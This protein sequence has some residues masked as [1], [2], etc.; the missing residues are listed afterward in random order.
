MRK[1]FDPLHYLYDPPV[2]GPLQLVLVLVSSAIY[3]FYRPGRFMNRR[4]SVFEEF[5]SGNPSEL[6][7]LISLGLLLWIG[8]AIAVT[9]MDYRN[10]HF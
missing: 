5:Q 6:A 4:P 1:L 3:L 2:R 9:I 10:G 7:V 8:Y